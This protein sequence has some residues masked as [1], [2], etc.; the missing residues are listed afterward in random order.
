[1]V[2]YSK[3]KDIEVFASLCDHPANVTFQLKNNETFQADKTSATTP[4]PIAG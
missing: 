1:M 4:M 3:W 2:D